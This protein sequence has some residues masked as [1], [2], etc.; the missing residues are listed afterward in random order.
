MSR[1]DDLGE[2]LAAAEALLAAGGEAD[3][4]LRAVVTAV[5]GRVADY[6]W[7][8]LRFNE[9]GQLLLGP[10]AGAEGGERLEQAVVYNGE[11]IGQLEVDAPGFGEADHAFLARLADLV[12][13]HTLLGWDTGGEAWEP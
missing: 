7:V 6:G 1:A 8:A 11:R 10:T 13:V 9:E 3:D 5:E 2:A 4:L 12:A